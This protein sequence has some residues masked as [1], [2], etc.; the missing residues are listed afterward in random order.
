MDERTKE[1]VRKLLA[2]ASN[3]PSIEEAAA[4]AN[5]SLGNSGRALKGGS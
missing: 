4:G 2:L 5:I 3:N 1:R